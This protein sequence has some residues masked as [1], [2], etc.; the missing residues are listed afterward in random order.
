M[1]ELFRDMTDG[2]CIFDEKG[3]L[4]YINASAGSILGLDIFRSLW[5]FSPI[6]PVPKIS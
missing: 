1:Y 6:R 4:K 3:C 5:I 2:V